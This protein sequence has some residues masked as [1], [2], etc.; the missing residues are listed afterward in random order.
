MTTDHAARASLVHLDPSTIIVRD[1]LRLVLPARVET[2]A[3][4]IR[5]AGMQQPIEVVETPDG[6]RLIK[7]GHRVAAALMAGLSTVPALLYPEGTFGSE[8]EIRVREISE[9]FVRFELNALEHANAI[10]E[11]REAHETLHGKPKRGRKA[12]DA[13][14]IEVLDEMSAKFAL[15]FPEVVQE[16]LGL[17]RRAVFLA[18]KIASIVPQVRALLAPHQVAG[19]QSELLAIAAEPAARQ[20]AI[21]AQLLAGAESVAAAIALIDNTTP[22]EPM[23]RW[24][25][26]AE[27]FS[28]LRPAEQERF[29]SLN[30]DAILAW[31][32]SRKG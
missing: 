10:A 13:A 31:V 14:S 18:L 29:F 22:P 3:L 19:N 15:N 17:S 25:K 11:W 8:A 9:N 30:Q 28:R 26:L 6:P 12:K 32:A 27:S 16:T 23:A 24:E 1:R 21:A 7:G 4:E 5:T 20:E 2:L